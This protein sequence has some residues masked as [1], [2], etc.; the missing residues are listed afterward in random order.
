MMEIYMKILACIGATALV[1][2]VITIAVGLFIA[3]KREF[4]SG[5]D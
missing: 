1:S 3:F 5:K 2:A 4:F